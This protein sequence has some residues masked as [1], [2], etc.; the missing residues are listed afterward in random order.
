MDTV[1]QEAAY[2]RKVQLNKYGFIYAL[3][4]PVANGTTLPAILTIEEDSD[5]LVEK[6]TGSAYGPT[7][8]NGIRQTAAATDFPLAGTT[9]GWADRGVSVKITDSGAGR[10][11]TNGLVPLETLLTPGYGVALFT[12]FNFKYYIRRNSKIQFDLRNRD[13][14][15]S[16]FHFVS[17]VLHGYKYTGV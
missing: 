7:D 5:F 4:V 1:Q 15:G 11:L 13:S 17:I 8:V 9:V 16:N 10:V 3:N 2:F 14:Q 6:F 12:P